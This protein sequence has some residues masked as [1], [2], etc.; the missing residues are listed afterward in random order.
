[1]KSKKMSFSKKDLIATFVCIVFILVT[2]GNV[3]STGRRRAKEAL[4]LSNLSRWGQ[5][6]LDYAADND[7]YFMSGWTPQGTKH[8]DYW[9]E[10]LR[11]YYVN[12][13]LRCCP[14]AAIPGT[15]SGGGQFGG[16][17]TFVGWGIFSLTDY[18]SADQPRPFAMMSLALASNQTQRTCQEQLKHR[19]L[20]CR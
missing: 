10:A 12:P 8:T 7:S 1:M 9:M 5:V 16:R 13:D 2:L 20:L 17:G 6:F 14:E 15:D 3:G 18:Y 4:C 19:Y 11:P